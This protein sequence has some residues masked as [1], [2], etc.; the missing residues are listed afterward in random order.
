MYVTAGATECREGA[1]RVGAG[2]LGARRSVLAA[3]SGLAAH[4]ELYQ[5]VDRF[6]QE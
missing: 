6:Y 1:V 2:D 5:D 3:V 4:A